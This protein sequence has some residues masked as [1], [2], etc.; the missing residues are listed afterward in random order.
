MA[1]K[2]IKRIED[3]G[4]RVRIVWVPRE[5]NEFADRAA[6]HGRLKGVE[7]SKEL[8]LDFGKLMEKFGN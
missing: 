2:L 8:P 3:Q 6:R 1:E 4:S 5:E 7:K